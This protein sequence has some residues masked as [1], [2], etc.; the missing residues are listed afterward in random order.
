[1]AWNGAHE[2]DD[3][4]KLVGEELA[5]AVFNS[6]AAPSLGIAPATVL[7]TTLANYHA[8]RAT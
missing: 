7:L 4:Q 6:N 5:L 1:V 2:T 3:L 8:P